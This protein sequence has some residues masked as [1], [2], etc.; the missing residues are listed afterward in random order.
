MTGVLPNEIFRV[1]S[2]NS[3]DPIRHRP[4]FF[5]VGTLGVSANLQIVRPDAIVRTC[6]PVAIG[7]RFPGF[8]DADD[9]GRSI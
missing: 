1:T 3:F 7:E 2:Q 9:I 6:I 5:G 4:C 8:V